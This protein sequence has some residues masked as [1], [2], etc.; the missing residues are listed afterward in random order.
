MKRRFQFVL[1]AAL[2]LSISFSAFSQEKEGKKTIA[3]KTENMQRFDGYFPFYWDEEK[4]KIWLEVTRLDEE[5]L[6]VNSLPAGIGSNDIGLDRG[7]LGDTRI[8]KFQKSGPKILLVQPNYDYR[9]VT[10]NAAE[11]RSV[12]QAF[13]QS[14]I[15]GFTADIIEDGRIL[16]DAT[17]FL[18]RDAHGV[19]GRLKGSRQGSYRLDDSRCAFYLPATMNFP[20][21]TEFEATLTFTGEPQGRW[22]RSVTPSPDAITVRQHHSFIEL[23]GDGYEMRKF[24]TRAGFNGIRFLDYATPISEPIM[25]R[26]ISRHRLE[27]KDPSA[28]TSEAVEPI[29]YYV[30]S[31]APEPIKSALIDGAMWW[32]QA[33]EAAGYKNAFQVKVMPVDAHPMDVRYNV[34][35]WVH[36]ST[37][38]WSYGSSVRD[39]RTGEIIKGHVTLGSLRVRQDFLIAEALLSPYSDGETIPPDM[40]EM[41]LARIRQLSAHEVGHTLGISHNFASSPT[42]R[43]SVMDYPHPLVKLKDSGEID[44]SEAYDDKIGAWDKVSIAFGYQDFPGGVNEDEALNKILEDAF[45]SGLRFIS[46]ADARPA[47]GLHPTAHLWDNGANPAD[48]LNR[49]MKVRKAMLERFSE[50]NIRKGVPMAALEEVFV[51]AYL[52][53]RYQVDA[54]SKLLGG[55]NYNY[56]V[57]G[58]NQVVAEIVPAS[59]QRSALDALLKTI[60]PRALAVPENILK[61]L[62]PRP[63]GYSRGRELF[64]SKTG[65]AF[66]PLTAAE[67]AANLTLGFLF[68][69]DRA[70]RLVD[71]HARNSQ[72]PGLGDVIDKIVA[73]TW[74]AKHVSAFHDQVQF[75]VNHAML[76]HLMALAANQNA[77]SQVQAVAMSKLEGLHD[78]LMEEIDG[79]SDENR[80]ASLNFGRAR[81]EAFFKN[82]DAFE[83]PPSPRT[84]DGSPIGSDDCKYIF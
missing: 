25:K 62:P 40:L 75:T 71:Y 13:A 11:K 78:W 84:P 15:W 64:S 58:G 31:G 42:S 53:H 57:R 21:N 16:V 8:V 32:N 79:E 46:D 43:A 26:Y 39:P 5:F 30:D 68:H 47:G 81:I 4:G 70:A 52:F 82:P 3:Q 66:D 50:R 27:K 6:Y 80:K 69:P 18:M 48:E 35:Q 7:Q 28:E 17:K 12:E 34:I 29:V 63:F 54:A 49:I 33:F 76:G 60:S 56:A 72:N 51:P 45:S 20:K 65:P 1:P 9:A 36:R 74:Q 19:I 24:D 44:L 83:P 23:P 41:A 55:L 61:I 37:R 2:I 10:D 73:S 59:D 67:T 14:V 38:G 77:A 22:I